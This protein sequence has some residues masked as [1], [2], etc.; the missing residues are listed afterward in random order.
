LCAD[1][2]R[3]KKSRLTEQNFPGRPSSAFVDFSEGYT[4]QHHTL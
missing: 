4:Y 3:Q 1:S 2:L